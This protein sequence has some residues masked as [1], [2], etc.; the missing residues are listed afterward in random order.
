MRKFALSLLL[1]AAFMQAGPSNINDLIR[2]ETIDRTRGLWDKDTA[3]L[4]DI[5]SFG[6]AA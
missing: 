4:N 6:P 3:A 1:L 2:D 5:I